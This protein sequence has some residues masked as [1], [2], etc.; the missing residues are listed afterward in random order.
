MSQC[1]VTLCVCTLLISHTSVVSVR[2][3][4]LFFSVFFVSS[5][6]KLSW[7]SF[8]MHSHINNLSHPPGGARACFEA[9]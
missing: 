6:S 1:L 9:M 5:W 3:L 2:S 4:V 7:L 8:D